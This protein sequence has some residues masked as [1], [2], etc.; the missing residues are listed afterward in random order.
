MTLDWFI[1][2]D[3]L[4]GALRPSEKDYLSLLVRHAEEAGKISVFKEVNS[5]ARC[6]AIKQ[7]I[8][9]FHILLHRNLWQQ[10][11]SY[12]SYMRD[13]YLGFY[14]RRSGHGLP[15]RRSLFLVSGRARSRAC[16]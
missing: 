10:W 13:G 9:G 2:L 6:W 12:L 7:A 16:G 3:G 15:R 11:T 1:P 8:G 5:L 14:H 4:R